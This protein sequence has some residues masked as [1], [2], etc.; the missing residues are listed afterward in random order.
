MQHYSDRSRSVDYQECPRSYYFSYVQPTGGLVGG[1]RPERL[2]MNLIVGG[3]F[4]EGINHILTGSSVDEA[5]GRALEGYGD[6]KGYWPQVKAYG[7]ILDPQEDASYVAWEQAS[8]AEALIRGYA[9]AV[10]PDLLNRFTAV[11]AE[12]DEHAVF[13][14]Q[15]FNLIWGMRG[16]ALLLEK[17]T[18]ELYILSLKT[19]KEWYGVKD[20]KINRYDMQGLSETATVDQRL[21]RWQ[22]IYDRGGS[23]GDLVEVPMWFR[24][25]AKTGASPVISAVKMEYALKGRRSE[26]PKGSG[27]WSFSNP[28]IRPWKKDDNLG[29][30]QYAFLFEFQDEAGGGHRLGKGWNRINIW[31][32]M[33]VKEWIQYLASVEMQGRPVGEG[34]RQQFVTPMEYYRNEEDMAVWLRQ[35]LYEERRI[36]LGTKEVLAARGTP[37]FEDKL[38]EHF[39]MYSNY[40]TNCTYC[41]FEDICHS[42]IKAYLLDPM[43]SQKFAPRIPNHKAEINVLVPGPGVSSNSGS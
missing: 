22:E 1:I 10:L 17:D 2:D 3:A 38:D 11:E 33:G 26:Y 9:Y 30:A 40:P 24:D 16:D 20:E 15:D 8:M 32:D 28:L 27:R 42:G 43:A 19:K 29:R 14:L 36:A 13:T 5:V 6:W 25:R 41:S 31:E 37:E 18:Q 12:R 23:E 35:R 7:L 4:H 34:I 39:P 21:Q